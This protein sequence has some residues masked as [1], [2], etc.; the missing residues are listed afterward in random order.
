MLLSESPGVTIVPTSEVGRFALF[1]VSL[2]GTQQPA[3]SALAITASASVTENLNKALANLRPQD[4]W[5]WIM[6]DD[7]CWEGDALTRML[8]VMD[9]DDDIDILVP[10][11]LKRNPPWHAV[12][13][14][15]SPDTDPEGHPLF[16]PFRF[17]EIP[18]T[19]VFEVA[20]AGS[21]GMLIRRHVLDQMGD[22]WF[23]SSV[24]KQGRRT[25]LSEDLTF[26]LRARG[27]GYRIHATADVTIGHI[28]VFRV[29]P[30]RQNGQWGALT[31]FSA[32]E[33]QYRTVYIPTDES[34]MDGL[35][36]Q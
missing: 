22:P 26:C 2:A 30:A 4:A 17:D 12:L 31:E 28:G 21:A 10:L 20:A 13:Y 11:C 24:D 14:H 35:V 1:T 7:H 27:L 6:G 3:G 32:V 9:D 18:D 23:Y 5:V 16:R 29:W 8:R 34:L 33:D 15:D 25:V 36:T 19:G